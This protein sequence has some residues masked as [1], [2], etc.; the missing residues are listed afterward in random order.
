MSE[1][2]L[3]KEQLLQRFSEAQNVPLEEAE[4][5]VGGEDADT[6]LNNIKNFT[7]QK[8]QE[9]MPPM[10]RAQRRAWMKKNRRLKGKF[11]DTAGTIAETA[12]KLN[13]I[14]LIQK[15]RALNEKKEKEIEDN[16]DSNEDN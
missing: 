15:L 1:E 7:Q 11:K 12:E 4:K 8:I 3:T 13:Y 5:L 9:H 14:D 16:E 10:N 2:K 6:I